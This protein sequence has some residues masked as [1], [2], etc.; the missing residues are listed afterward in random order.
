MSIFFF[1]KKIP[2]MN[3]Q[4]NSKHRNT[5]SG[6][7]PRGQLVNKIKKDKKAPLKPLN[8]INKFNIEIFEK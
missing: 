8:P 1:K 3:V 7:L 2:F 6:I 5:C 4:Y